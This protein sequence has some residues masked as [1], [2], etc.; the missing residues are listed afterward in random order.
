MLFHATCVAVGNHGVLLTGAP[1]SGKSDVA[2]RLIETGAELVADDQVEL[3]R[4]GAA[5]V[6]TVP[7]P[8]A[9]MIEV[10]HVG[11]V[12]MPYRA[13]IQISLYVTLVPA[14]EKITR[15]PD[16][17]PFTLLDYPIRQLKLPAYAASTPTKIRTALLHPLVTDHA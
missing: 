15:L 4:A 9:G 5:L 1:G 3:H 6:A 13:S 16:S 8:I 7:V 11:L 12:R 17:E 10:R 14:T 2:L